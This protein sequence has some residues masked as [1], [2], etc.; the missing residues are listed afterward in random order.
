MRQRRFWAGF[1]DASGLR[2]PDGGFR[3]SYSCFIAESQ[4]CALPS[5]PPQPLPDSGARVVLAGKGALTGAAAALD[6]A[7]GGALVKAVASAQVRR[8]SGGTRSN[9]SAT[10]VERVLVAGLGDKPDDAAWER[11]GGA[12]AAKLL[13]SGETAVTVDFAGVSAGPEAAA[14]LAH[15]AVLRSYRFD[16]YRTTMKDKAKPTLTSLTIVNAPAG[17]E[18]AFA[19]LAAIA[20]GVELTRDLVSEP[21]NIIYPESFV[22]RARVL[23]D[24]GISIEVLGEPEMRALGMGALLGVSL[25]SEREAKLL[26]MKWQRRRRRQAGGAGR[27]GRHL[28]H[29]RHLAE[30]ACRHGRHEVGH[31]RG[32]GGDRRDARHRGPERQGQCHRRLRPRREHARRQGAAPGRCRHLDVGPDHRGHQHRC[33]R[34]GWCCATRSGGRRRRSRPRSSSTW[35][36]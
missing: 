11:I 2:R 29:R 28:R 10:A 30:A 27:Q 14:R 4:P 1:P 23:A 6:A 32:W 21:A 13:T 12:I 22:E 26:V 34:D 36:R 15:G 17:C 8:R 19:P 31:G 9:C 20:A 33:R 18:A 16:K 7:M 5:L 24:A 25:G 35:R 3:R